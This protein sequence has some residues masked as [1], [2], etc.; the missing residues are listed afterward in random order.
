MRDRGP[1]RT[2]FIA[3]GMSVGEYPPYPVREACARGLC[4]EMNP[5]DKE[6]NDEL[7]LYQTHTVWNLSVGMLELRTT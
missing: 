3:K 7:L 2:L 6:R 1:M 4:S 5:F